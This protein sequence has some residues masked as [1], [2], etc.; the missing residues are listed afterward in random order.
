MEQAKALS[1]PS[2]L[3]PVSTAI[4][5]QEAYA[6]FAGPGGQQPSYQQLVYTDLRSVHS[7]PSVGLKAMN[8][9]PNACMLTQSQGRRSFRAATLAHRLVAAHAGGFNDPD[10]LVVGLEGM[11]P[12]GERTRAPFT[13][14]APR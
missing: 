11:Y 6:D 3:Q 7:P 4:K 14:A 12:Y 2:F 10:M 1:L 9:K 8:C 5:Q 13:V